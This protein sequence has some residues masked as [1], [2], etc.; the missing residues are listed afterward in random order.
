[1]KPNRI[2]IQDGITLPVQG[3]HIRFNNHEY[4]TSDKKEIAFIKGHRLFGSQITVVEE[5]KDDDE[6]EALKKEA[7]EL[8]VEYSANI[9]AKTLKE[10]I[11][12]AKAGE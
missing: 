3:E 1:M 10:R 2:Q 9:G 7:D 11:E 4:E 8:G 5:P 12:K 6:L